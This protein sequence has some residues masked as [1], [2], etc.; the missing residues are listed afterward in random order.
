M[1]NHL[2]SHGHRVNLVNK[3]PY[4]KIVMVAEDVD[5]ILQKKFSKTV[6]EICQPIYNLFDV[7]FFSHTRA[8]H[9][10]QFAM[11]LTHPELKEYHLIKKNPI[12][13]SDGKGFYLPSGYYNIEYMKK[14]LA[15]ANKLKFLS[16]EFN[17]QHV[18]LAV[19]KHPDYDDMFQFGLMGREGE[20][21]NKFFNN[22]DVIK[23][24]LLYFKSKSLD[25]FRRI[26]LI[27]YSDEYF[28]P[29]S[30]TDNSS[31]LT[32]AQREKILKDMVLKKVELP[33]RL[34]NVCLSQREYECFQYANKNLSL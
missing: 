31:L 22:I 25:L 17:I 4:P 27:R 16:D 3:K 14:N 5:L 10:G 20:V 12:Q 2:N 13:F 26:E 8:F 15:I 32:I 1:N 7:A 29:S 28:L 21:I 6:I 30:E 9:D 34:G 33:G 23:H 19:E 18:I 11:L 24:F